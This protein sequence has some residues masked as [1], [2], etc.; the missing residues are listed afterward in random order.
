MNV[1]IYNADL[2]CQECGERIKAELDAKGETPANPNNERTFDSDQYPKGPYPDG[3]GESDSPQHCGSGAYCANFY[4]LGWIK[5]GVFLENK[6]TNDGVN[7]VKDAISKG[8]PVADFWRE[9]YKE[10]GYRV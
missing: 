5:V 10:M 7:Y 8:G 2:F 9:K 1:Y 6:L 3:G 4:I